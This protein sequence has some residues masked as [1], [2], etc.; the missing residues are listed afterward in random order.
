M[1][2]PR[3]IEFMQQLLEA[4]QHPDIER[5][6]TFDDPGTTMK[7]CG[8]KVTYRGGR[9]AYLKITRSSPPT[10]DDF[11]TGEHI[12]YPDYSIPQEVRSCHQTAS[13][14]GAAR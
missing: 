3:L 7:P 9:V 8:I 1:R 6:E 12:P 5:V 4:G 2:A 11:S 10:G 14:A 13:A